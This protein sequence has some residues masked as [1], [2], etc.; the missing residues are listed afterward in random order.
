MR[1]AS[2]GVIAKVI[3]VLLPSQ[4]T[5]RNETKRDET[6][7][8]QGS[9]CAFCG[10]SKGGRTPAGLGPNCG[11]EL[12]RN[13]RTGIAAD[14]GGS[15]WSRWS[16][17]AWSRGA[18]QCSAGCFYLTSLTTKRVAVPGAP[19]SKFPLRLPSSSKPPGSYVNIGYL[20]LFCG[21]YLH[22]LLL[23]APSLAGSSGCCGF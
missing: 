3:K 11:T 14:V 21:Q 17:S 20:T 1:S 23:L 13:E 12:G 9:L 18:T 7:T 22:L 2:R 16:A 4:E 10:L 8:K 15:C 6:S 19:C 5:R